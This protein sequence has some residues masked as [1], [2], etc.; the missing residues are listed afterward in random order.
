MLHKINRNGHYYEDL[1]DWT[2]SDTIH[3]NTRPADDAIPKMDPDI[4][5]FQVG[6]EDNELDKKEKLDESL[7]I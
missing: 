5:S 6:R 3:P 4:L 7:Y 2:L 1:A